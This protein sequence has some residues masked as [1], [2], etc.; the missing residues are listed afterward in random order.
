MQKPSETLYASLFWL[1]SGLFVWLLILPI[2]LLSLPVMLLVAVGKLIFTV[3]QLNLTET[4]IAS[5]ADRERQPVNANKPLLNSLLMTTIIRVPALLASGISL[6]PTRVIKKHP[7]LAKKIEP[8]PAEAPINS[9]L[10]TIDIPA[11]EK[12]GGS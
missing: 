11:E 4:E 3:P 8:Q 1:I 6:Q 7:L 12:T 10:D 2:A 5:Q 9:S